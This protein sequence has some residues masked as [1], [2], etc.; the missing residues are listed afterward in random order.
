[1]S[2]IQVFNYES[3]EIR[4]VEHDGDVWFVAQ[5]VC[6][7]LELTDTSKT[8]N[9]LDEDEKLVRKL[10]VSGQN[11][12]V[13]LI[14]ESGLYALILRSNKP[15]AKSF[16]K[17]VTGTVLPSIRQ[18]GFYATPATAQKILDDP[19]T[20]I[21]VLQAYKEQK[22]RNVE[23]EAKNEF[24]EQVARSQQRQIDSNKPKVIF[25][26]AVDASNDSILVGNLAKILRQ[27]G[28]NIGQNRLF[29]WLRDNGYLIKKRGALHNMPTQQSMERGYFEVKTSIVQNPDGSTRITRTTKVTGKGQVYFVNLFLSK[30][31]DNA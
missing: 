15:N 28:V 22:A 26:E 1:M 5:D 2:D 9:R 7:V 20:F 6:D 13:L 29:A 3:N 27:N 14:N 19:D 31:I 23:L 11:R 30:G 10:F 24:L 16:R 8:C 17:W 21:Q 18:H 4:T 12:D 25:A